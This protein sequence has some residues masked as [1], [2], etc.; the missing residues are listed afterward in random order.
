[1]LNQDRK[2]SIVEEVLEVETRAELKALVCDLWAS[3]ENRD[4]VDHEVVGAIKCALSR[5]RLN[6]PVQGVVEEP[7]AVVRKE[8]DRPVFRAKAKYRILRMDVGWSTKP[9][10]KQIM[11][12]IAARAAI[13]D[14]LEE[15]EILEILA[16]NVETRQPI[17][18]IWDYYKG[19]WTEGLEAHG[20][21]EKV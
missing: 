14:V 3:D 11:E 5:L 8:A 13:G 9:Q 10:V 1:M 21:I 19:D 12:A 18:K 6:P 7:V 2:V 16:G 15:S 20:N 4:Y 17:K